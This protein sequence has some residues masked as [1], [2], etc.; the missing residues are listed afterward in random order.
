MP[1]Q[2]EVAERACLAEAVADVAEDG[3]GLLLM[4]GGL[5]VAAQVVSARPML[6][7]TRSFTGP[8]A[9]R[10]EQGQRLPVVV[11]GLL[12]AALLPVGIADL[13]EGRCLGGAVTGAAGGIERVTEDG[14]RPRGSD[15]R[16]KVAGEGGG[17]PGG[18]AGPA[19]GG[20]VRGDRHQGGAFARPAIPARRP[21]SG[22]GGTGVAGRGMR[23]RRWRSAG[24]RVSIAAAAVCR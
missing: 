12:E 20:G 8:V 21:G 7:S 4:A 9:C 14:E 18:M 15:R 5:L 23:G 10:A 22:S 24:S 19:V 16:A 6:P 3:D 17:Q 11:S 1:G 2:A 13:V